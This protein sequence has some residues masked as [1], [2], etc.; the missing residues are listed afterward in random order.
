MI[1]IISEEAFKAEY[2]AISKMRAALPYRK[3]RKL[4]GAEKAE[5]R[6]LRRKLKMKSMRKR[7]LPALYIVQIGTDLVSFEAA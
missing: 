1:P 3:P 4:N 6:R 5:L 7:G 2:P